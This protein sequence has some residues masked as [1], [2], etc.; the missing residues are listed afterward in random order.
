MTNYKVM[1]T[2][3]ELLEFAEQEELLLLASESDYLAIADGLW[4]LFNK[5]API[6]ECEPIGEIQSTNADDYNTQYWGEL[7]LKGLGEGK[8]K[9]GDK[10]YTIPP[11][12]KAKIATLEADKQRLIEALEK[13]IKTLRNQTGI[14]MMM[15]SLIVALFVM[16]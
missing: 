2:E 7:D 11:D 8:W 4:E 12:A 3:K 15:L 10:L 9:V 1:P 16:Q 13:I 5:Q 6:V 14:I